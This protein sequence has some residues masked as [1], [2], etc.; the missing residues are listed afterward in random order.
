[1]QPDG[2][3]IVGG[4]FT[5]I[6]GIVRNHIARIHQDGTLDIGFEPGSGTDNPIYSMCLRPDGHVLIGGSFMTY[7]GISTPNL[8]LVSTNGGLDTSFD[9]GTG[10]NGIVYAIALD[11]DGKILVGGDFTEINGIPCP[12]IAR[13]NPDGTLD[14]TF[15]PGLGVDS[16]VRTIVV[17]P[18]GMILI[19]GSFTAINGVSRLFFARLDARGQLDPSFL[20]GNSNDV[21]ANDAVYAACLQ[22]DGKILVAGSFTSFNNVTRFRITRLNPDGTTD[23]TIN[24][25]LGANSFISSVLVQPDRK[26]LIA[27]GFTTF[28]EQPRNYLARVYGGSIDGA[29]T[30]QFTS[31]VFSAFENQPD[32]PI[33]MRR[34]GGLSGTVTVLLT[35]TPGTAQADV[36][37]RNTNSII[38]FLEGEVL[39]TFR[40]PVLT[41]RPYVTLPRTVNL[42]LTNATAGAALGAQPV[43]TLNILSDDSIVGFDHA[44]Y[45]VTEST[46][47]GNILI[48]VR[49]DPSGATNTAVSVDY[50]TYDGTAINGVDYN[51]IYGT[52]NF[53]PGDMFKTFELHVIND[54][55]A[56]GTRTVL[57]QLV[58]P[59]GNIALGV[60]SAVLNIFDDDLAIGEL[61]LSAANF[62]VNEYETNVVVTVLRTNGSSNPV[63][64][65]YATT[66]GS[67]YNGLD[68]VSSSGTVTFYD[69]E[70]VKYITI[71]ILQNYNNHT[72]ASFSLALSGPTGGA[73]IGNI[74]SAIIT[75]INTEL[76][77]GSFSFSKSNYGILENAGMAVLTVN[78]NFGFQGA[79]SVSYATFDISAQASQD[80]TAVTNTLTWVDGDRNPKTIQ[81]S[82]ANDTVVEGDDQFGVRL[83]NP[84]NG[85]TL[86]GLVNASV[87]ITNDD[88]GPGSLTFSASNYDVMKNGTN[89]ALQVF[90]VLGNT[91]TVSVVFSTSDGLGSN[92]ATNNADYLGVTN[93]LTFTPGVTN[94]SVLIPIIDR[95]AVEMDKKFFVKISNPSNGATLGLIT[96]AVVTIVENQPQ[97]GSIDTTFISQG[98]NGQ[99]N[100]VVFQTN[101]SKILAGG[102]FTRF[103][104][105]PRGRLAR[106]NPNGSL[107]TAFDATNGFNS[108]VRAIA[109]Q[110]DGE[111][112]VGGSFTSAFGG[113]NSY[114]VRLNSD[115][116]LD[117]NFLAG[118]SGVDNMVEAIAIQPIDGK[119]V[120]GGQ[121]STVNGQNRYHIARL[122]PNGQIDL[123]FN[124]DASAGGT[125]RAL[126]VGMDGR[127]LMA[128]DFLSANGV[129]R[130][131]IAILDGNGNLDTTFDPGTGPDASVRSAVFFNDDIVIGGLFQHYNGAVAPR[132]ARL[133]NQGQLN[134][135]FAASVGIGADEFVS[136]MA[137]RTNKI[138]VVGG[139]NTFNGFEHHRITRLTT[140]GAVDPSINFGAGA[141]SYIS[142]IALQPDQK[143]IIGGGFTSF[144]GQTRYYIA[145]LNDG[146]NVG[147]G[148]LAFSSIN[149]SVLESAG[150]VTVTVRRKIGTEGTIHVDYAT[151]DKT[152]YAGSNYVSTSGTL[153]FLP[154]ETVKSF[155]IGISNDPA[156]TPDRVFTVTLSNPS[157]G[158]VLGE[159]GAAAV[160]I[161]NLNSRIE[162]SLA[163][164]SISENAG[165]AEISV[166]RVGSAVGSNTVS[167]STTN[168]T[169]IDGV[170]YTQ[171]SGTLTFTNGQTNAI[172]QVPIINDNI[173][174]GD[175][176]VALSLSSP[177]G[178][179]ILGRSAAALTII[180]DDFSAGQFSFTP[181]NYIVN[182]KAGSVLVT[183]AR[184]GG[185][186]GQA[187][188]NFTTSDGSAVGGFDYTRTNGVLVFADGEV[189]KTI[190][191]R[192]LDDAFVEDNEVFIVTLF[193]AVGATIAQNVATVVI[194]ANESVFSLSATNYIVYEGSNLVAD[195]VV[196]RV[197]LTNGAASVT[198]RTSDGTAIAGLDYAFT[199]LV[200]NFADGETVKTIPVL[201]Y[202]DLLGEGNEYFSASLSSPSTNALIGSNQRAIVT[203]IDNE[204]IFSLSSPSYVV[205]ETTTNAVITIV[206]TGNPSSG[207]SVVYFTSNI[208]AVAGVNYV[209]VSNVLYLSQYEMTKTFNIPILDD[210]TATGDLTVGIR[211]QGLNAPA[212]TTFLQPTNAILTIVDSS[213]SIGFATNAYYV[214]EDIGTIYLSATRS[215]MISN[216]ITVNYNTT[217]GTA[218]AG[219]DYTNR[220]GSITFNPGETNKLIAVPITDDSVVE[221]TETFSVRLWNTNLT[222]ITFRSGGLT[223]VT[224]IDNDSSIIVPSGTA[225]IAE[226]LLINGYIDVNETVTV[227]FGLRNIGNVPT[228]DLRA[229]LLATNGIASPSP[230]SQSYGAMSNATVSRPFQ[231][232]ASTTN[233]GTITAVFT[234]LDVNTTLHVT[235]NLGT[236]SFS[237]IVGQAQHSYNSTNGSILINDNTIA[238]PYPS[239]IVVSNLVGKVTKVTLTLK[240]YDH[241]FP[242]DVDMLLV[243]P[244]GKST[245][246]M[247]DAGGV[248]AV[249]G[250][251]LTFDDSATTFI[252]KT[253]D[254]YGIVT[255]TYKPTNYVETYHGEE[256][257]DYFP[258]PAPAGPWT[259][260]TLQ[261]LTGGDPNGA[262]KLYI[263]DDMG[264]NAGAIAGGW[265]LN[266]MTSGSDSV[267]ADL[268]T[269]ALSA[270][271]DTVYG[272]GNTI[273]YSVTVRNDGPASASSV[274]VTNTLDANCTYVGCD[275]GTAGYVIVTNNL[276]II[277]LGDIT[278]GYT[279]TYHLQVTNRLP[280]GVTSYTFGV[281]IA[282]IQTDPALQN[283][284]RSVTI[285]TGTP[286]LGMQWNTGRTSLN[287]TWPSAAST[288]ILEM[289]DTL[290]PANWVRVTS[291][292]SNGSQF[293]ATL[294]PT[295]S[296][297]FFRLRNP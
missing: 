114:L 187:A 261:A 206:R 262:W 230:S 29:G 297:K 24:F 93:L 128:G 285:G 246:F 126:Q 231:F 135:A 134:T 179:A 16:T 49:R 217:N 256:T 31:A 189:S 3:V 211:I 183:V 175:R 138:F 275:I 39:Q 200:L 2:K 34:F 155:Q 149:Y 30:V 151:S 251:N 55:I 228:T 236:V 60:N 278:N 116:S 229:S 241:S 167:Y 142:T 81:V 45:G 61:N 280:V 132:V 68:Y 69:G 242:A 235:N 27:G 150:T 193:D 70:T 291:Y 78:R 28:D 119:I 88:Y 197:G 111:I 268:E 234:L 141:N 99:V 146:E 5:S 73:T 207:V 43:A 245:V 257:V 106:I 8:A 173:V 32:A 204:D 130:V 216:T 112:L 65:N 58:N 240:N 260:S 40:I 94:A 117:T 35:N 74:P 163:N 140:G 202:D 62:T 42:F 201:I 87:T 14:S 50:A 121:F 180:E 195:I 144:D 152:A 100:V 109:V 133:N 209:S 222:N 281:N 255:G 267:S 97:A 148:S 47:S 286:S 77:N 263:V 237:F 118:L 205:D 198:L 86:G 145:R 107:D 139:F 171:V 143:I 113:P 131:R 208:T 289:T 253:P 102:D 264:W 192:I 283:N 36:D 162:F 219:L 56:K 272:A 165:F 290:R 249:S 238:D 184:Q 44:S 172:F 250:I 105:V 178:P 125:V 282:A 46:P 51:T 18:D 292:T 284:S 176:Q 9:A 188:V 84:S 136:A 80:Y 23:P 92:G 26:I 266:L 17:Q 213:I 129:S 210:K 199:N 103:D 15:N 196:S 270:S 218:T 110:T 4:L 203:I 224:I 67:G 214:N 274:F 295:N 137:T 101:S 186:D 66:D 265:T 41:N 166:Q 22:S 21:G 259:N 288:Y 185:S 48:T 279:R 170:D 160:T 95:A 154:G 215:G 85:A 71:P 254:L 96:T 127:I 252:P 1:L 294:N 181:A 147:Q 248:V 159:P 124:A 115:G 276:A 247:S 53:A 75:I 157:G 10:P 120:I 123:S 59:T 63:E 82:I 19:G 54:N 38:T 11:A 226:N 25:G 52:L 76:I 223:T 33:T 227:N 177:T 64:V 156:I 243:N 153:T 212:T 174:R 233:G 13:L 220:S 161:Q 7:N 239:T 277:S 12:R 287:L 271:P 37:Y 89:V 83:F 6:D 108:S 244:Q 293:I 57:L 72:N 182:E 225:L 90:R 168:M 169:A 91:G 190:A 104:N 232:T 98:A 258:S 191:I 269:A 158:A 122:H 273:T 194:T 164:Y 296:T 221:D 79:V 20:D